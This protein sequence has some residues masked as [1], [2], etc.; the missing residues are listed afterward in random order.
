MLSGVRRYWVCDVLFS[1]LG[2]YRLV[3]GFEI[4]LQSF[5]NLLQTFGDGRIQRENETFPTLNLSASSHA[6]SWLYNPPQSGFKPPCEPDFA[7]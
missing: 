5:L 6:Q 2:V 3:K 4:S 7:G 1:A